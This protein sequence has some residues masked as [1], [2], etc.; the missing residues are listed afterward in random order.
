ML[1]AVLFVMHTQNGALDLGSIER[2]LKQ[3]RAEAGR[4]IRQRFKSEELANG[5]TPFEQGTKVLFAVD[6]GDG[7]HTVRVTSGE[8]EVA[9]LRQV[10]QNLFVAVKEFDDGAGMVLDYQVDGK[11]RRT[12]IPLEVYRPNPFVQAPPGGR[13]G[14]LRDMGEWKST[15]FPNTTRKWYVYLP[16]NLDSAKEYPVLIATDAQWDRDWIANGLENCAREGV[17]PATVGVFI[18]PGQDRPGNYSN[19]SFEYDAL[20]PRYTEF[21]L[22]EILP[23]VE[24]MVK[25]SRDPAKR[26]LTGMS[27]GGICS[28]T[29]CWERPD[30]FGAALS[31]IGSFANIA[32]GSSKREG[33]HNYPFLVRKTEKKPI[34][35]FLQDGSNDLNNDHGS[36]WICNLQMESALRYKGYDVV[37]N[38]GNG[39]HSTKHAR[40]IFDLA[41]KW[42]LG[43]K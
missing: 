41:L 3:D 34:R 16:P 30:Q 8:H 7:K 19:R 33:G 18:E 25:L 10:D 9:T 13:K 15:I 29:A 40:R 6:A 24:K 21:L 26:A 20:T 23:Q 43:P 35:I 32:S 11:A 27:S 5:I 36:W 37:W 2:L 14:E 28:F 38:P 4:M 22:N 1:L 31:F 39:F 12:G 17:V 42:W